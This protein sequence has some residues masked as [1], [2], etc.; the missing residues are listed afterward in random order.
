AGELADLP[1]LSDAAVNYAPLILSDNAERPSDAAPHLPLLRI[2]NLLLS[3]GAADRAQAILAE[4]ER[5]VRLDTLEPIERAFHKG[6]AARLIR[7][8]WQMAIASREATQCFEQSGD[9]R[10][11]TQLCLV[12]VGVLSALGAFEEAAPLIEWGRNMANRL[13]LFREMV[14]FD[15]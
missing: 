12:H 3:V 9:F 2:V 1:A 8:P 10:R 14:G 6:A 13:G 4:F 11:A 5:R 7:D 15:S